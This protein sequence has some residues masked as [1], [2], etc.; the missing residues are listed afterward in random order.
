MKS[1]TKRLLL[2]TVTLD[3]NKW[4]RNMAHFTLLKVTVTCIWCR[5]H[6]SAINLSLT[7]FFS[8]LRPLLERVWHPLS[9]ILYEETMDSG[10]RSYYVSKSKGGGDRESKSRMKTGGEK[11]ERGRGGWKGRS[12]SYNT[13]KA[14][15]WRNVTWMA[16][17]EP[18]SM[19]LLPSSVAM[20]RKT[21][22]RNLSSHGKCKEKQETVRKW[23][24]VLNKSLSLSFFEWVLKIQSWQSAHGPW[25]EKDKRGA[26][27]G[28]LSIV[29]V[30]FL[31]ALAL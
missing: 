19:R 4:L 13:L 2:L 27:V 6:S 23:I 16:I 29:F 8:L 10:G 17:L 28:G 24:L 14:Q 15:I 22:T 7:S 20:S 21:A 12:L 31:S 9:L 5:R 30:P 11:W 18:P 26:E 3:E 1:S 25:M